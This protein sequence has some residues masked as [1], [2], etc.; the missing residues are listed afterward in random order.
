MNRE[1][2]FYFFGDAGSYDEYNPALILNRLKAQEIIYFIAS[3]EPFSIEKSDI[4]NALDIEEKIV[5]DIL[6]D[7]V[8][9]NAIEERN[10]SYRIDFPIFL[11]EDVLNIEKFLYGVGESIGNKIVNIKEIILNELKK[12]SAYNK[13]SNERLLYHIICDYVFDRI[14]FEFFE[15][16]GLFCTSKEQIGNRDYL[17]VAYEKSEVVSN[18]SN[19]LLCS[20]NNYRTEKYTFNSFGDCNGNRKDMFRFLNLTNLGINNST[21]FEELN[22]SYIK[23]IERMNKELANKCGELIIKLNLENLKY[24]DLTTE[25]KE[26]ADFLINME[27]LKKEEGRNIE[28]NIPIFNENDKKIIYKIGEIILNEIYEQVNKILISLEDNKLNI[29]AIK[30]K[31]KIKEILNEMWHQIFGLTNE[32]LCNIGFVEKPENKDC[33]GRYLKSFCWR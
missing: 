14:A 11:E 7:M 2:E 12:I 15:E 17:I 8:K 26:I 4:L 10:N 24:E 20:S 18:H 21:K 31:V 29:T 23:I 30:H 32:Y 19:R 3:N 1:M 13:Y 5:E 6:Y 16:K 25:E 27:Y 33:E 22:F 28:L 9:I